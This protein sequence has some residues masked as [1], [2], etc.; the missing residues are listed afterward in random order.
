MALETRYDFQFLE[1][2]TERAVLDELERQLDSFEGDICKCNDCVVDMAAIALNNAP[3]YYHSSVLGEL[4]AQARRDDPKYHEN[5]QHVVK[6]AIDRVRT[7]P[8]HEIPLEEEII[9]VDANAL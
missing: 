1:N 9:V 5:I 6:D 3:P 7:N 8:S 2:E 4:Y